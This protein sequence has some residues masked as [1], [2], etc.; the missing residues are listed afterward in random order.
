MD[1]FFFLK[2]VCQED[3]DWLNLKL[4]G[5]KINHWIIGKEGRWMV[6]IKQ[7]EKMTDV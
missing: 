2:G 5:F 4:N 7:R 1:F 3:E 6:E